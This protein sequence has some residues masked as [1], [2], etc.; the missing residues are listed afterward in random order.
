MIENKTF[1]ENYKLLCKIHK[2]LGTDNQ[3][4]LLNQWSTNVVNA[5]HKIY[6]DCS[7]KVIVEMVP[8]PENCKGSDEVT[9]NIWKTPKTIF[10]ENNE[11]LYAKPFITMY[12]QKQ[13]NLEGCVE[14]INSQIDQ[15]L[16]LHKPPA[17]IT[18]RGKKYRLVEEE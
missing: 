10:T 17:T 12:S 11:P 18:V 6:S 2:A 3:I 9:I 7:F 1:T 8:N 16:E 15:L 5:L 4:E 13:N 14:S